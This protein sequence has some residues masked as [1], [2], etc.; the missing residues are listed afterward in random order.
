M[1]N[2]TGPGMTEAEYADW[3]NVQ[4]TLSE[5]VKGEFYPDADP[6][7]DDDLREQD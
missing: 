2:R 7:D 3:L 6:E 4:E 1:A 5:E